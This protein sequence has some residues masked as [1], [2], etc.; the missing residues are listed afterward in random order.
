MALEAIVCT[1]EMA[2]CQKINLIEALSLMKV[3]KIVNGQGKNYVKNWMH[4]YTYK[5]YEVCRYSKAFG[6]N[7]I[8]RQKK[9]YIYKWVFKCIQKLYIKDG[10]GIR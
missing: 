6:F 3:I 4:S 2:I 9:T 5:Y 10:S 7:I 1:R 8:Y